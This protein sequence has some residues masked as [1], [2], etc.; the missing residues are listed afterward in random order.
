[1]RRPLSILFMMR[2]GVVT[3][4]ALNVRAD[5]STNHARIGSLPKGAQVTVRN[6][7]GAWFEIEAPKV[8]WVAAQYIALDPPV[9]T[10]VTPVVKPPVPAAFDGPLSERPKNRNEV[11]EMFGDPSRG[12]AYKHD[13][14]PTW[15]A[16]NIVE[17]HGN[18]AFLPV[19]AKSYFPIHH[20]IEP[21]AREAFERAEA[22]L[23]GYIRRAGT[24]GYNFRHIRHNPNF[25]LSYHSWGIA[26]DVNPGDN[27]AFDFGAGQTPAPWSAVWLKRWPR[28]VPEAIVS[29]FESCGFSWG[30]HWRGYCDP[31]HFEWLGA[32]PTQV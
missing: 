9:Q 24:W 30:G 10:G 22:A 28:G 3:V 31:M 16:Q 17:L 2:T 26:I 4:S 29:A 21:Y 12:G 18:N 25:P 11:L 15:R 23:P 1:M 14:D 19:L 27:S 5:P 13:A 32:S 6:T 8:G 7:Q 20:D